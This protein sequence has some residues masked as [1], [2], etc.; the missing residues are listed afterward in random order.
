M[1]LRPSYKISYTK[2]KQQQQQQQWQTMGLNKW[3]LNLNMLKLESCGKNNNL[4]LKKM[5]F[6]CIS[7]KGLMYKVYKIYINN[8][9]TYSPV[10]NGQKMWKV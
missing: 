10:E 5:L 9:K 8:E 6:I 1:S 7:D 2:Y 4:Y 3:F